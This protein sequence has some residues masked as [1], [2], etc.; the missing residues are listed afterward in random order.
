MKLIDKY[1]E[2]LFEHNALQE[3]V[4]KMLELRTRELNKK[5]KKLRQNNGYLKLLNRILGND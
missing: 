4:T 5:N 3:K 2:L 1:I